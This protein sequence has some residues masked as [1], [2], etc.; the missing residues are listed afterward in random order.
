MGQFGNSASLNHV[1]YGVVGEI[2]MITGRFN[3]LSRVCFSSRN[4]VAKAAIKRML[5]VCFHK[6][7]VV[8]ESKGDVSNSLTL[9][10]LLLQS[11]EIAQDLVYYFI[12]ILNILDYHCLT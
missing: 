9:P 4:P 12:D 5:N 3:V 6:F 11:I 2:R 8:V 1:V 7:P 10:F